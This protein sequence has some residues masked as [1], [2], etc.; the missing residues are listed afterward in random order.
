MKIVVFCIE[1][2]IKIGYH[3]RLY[4]L[5]SPQWI[6]YSV[7]Q[8]NLHIQVS[9][10]VPAIFMCN[11]EHHD[12]LQTHLSVFIRLFKESFSNIDLSQSLA[13]INMNNH[14]IMYQIQTPKNEIKSLPLSGSVSTSNLY[15]SL[16]LIY[17]CML[18]AHWC[19]FASP[20]LC[21]SYKLT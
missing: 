14:Y 18:Q 17:N 21:M 19:Y 10:S 3:S 8:L 7:L 20:N 12:T 16:G 5:H 13:C 1:T 2:I 9:A 6:S 4:F 11:L 15:F